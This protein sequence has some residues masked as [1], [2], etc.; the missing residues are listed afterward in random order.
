MAASALSRQYGV[1]VN[2]VV[3]D[4]AT[5][6]GLST[7]EHSIRQFATP[8]DLLVNTAGACTS[9]LFWQRDIAQE[10]RLVQLNSIATMR[11]VHIC[12]QHMVER[13]SGTIINMSSITASGIA[14]THS[15]YAATKA[16]LSSFSESLIQELRGTGVT[17]TTVEPAFVETQ[18][19]A[20]ESFKPPLLARAVSA[21]HVARVSIDYASRGKPLCV[22]GVNATVIRYGLRVTPRA[23]LRPLSWIATRNRMRRAYASPEWA[24]L[25]AKE[26]TGSEPTD[27]TLLDDLDWSMPTARAYVRSQ[28]SAYPLAGRIVATILE[29][30]WGCRLNDNSRSLL[31]DTMTALRYVNDLIDIYGVH[32]ARVAQLLRSSGHFSAYDDLCAEVALHGDLIAFQQAAE[33]LLWFSHCQRN[34]HPASYISFRRAEG[35]VTG[36]LLYFAIAA[37]VPHSIRDAVRCQ[38]ESIGAAANLWDTLWDLRED[39]RFSALS[40]TYAVMAVLAETA[41]VLRVSPRPAKLLQTLVRLVARFYLSQQARAKWSTVTRESKWH[42]VRSSNEQS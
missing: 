34:A 24:T 17:V 26:S 29:R 15:T 1:A 7:V 8:I 18:M 41:K 13:R 10:S 25:E 35:L 5:E 11:L 30:S 12:L 22:P 3:C 6:Q 37:N 33:Q 9:G 4:L 36:Q 31:V 40:Q 38:L 39:G 20:I 21:E 32:E 16:F 27:L 2:V 42:P 19:T 14:P 23:L 28:N